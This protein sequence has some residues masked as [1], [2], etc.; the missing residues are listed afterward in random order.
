MLFNSIDFMIF[1]PIV[2]AVYFVIPKSLRGGGRTAWLLIAS[3]YFYM[4]WNPAYALLIAGST[5]VTF[6]SGILIERCSGAEDSQNNHYKRMVLILCLMIN[7]GILGV[8]KYGN[9]LIDSANEVLSIFHITTISRRF[10]LLLPV[11]I[12]F[13]T[14][15]ALGYIID[16]YRNDIKAEKNIVRYA[17]F[18][19][20]F[21]QLVAGPIERSKNLLSQIQNISKIKLWNAKRVTSGAILMVWGYF[22]KMVIADRVSLLVDTVFDN[23]RM[24]GSTELIIAAIGFSIQIYCDFGSYSLIAIGAA[25]IRG[26]ELMENFNT[27]Y[28]AHNIRDFWSRWHI[29]LSTWFRDYLYIPL[30]GNRKGKVRKAANLMIV[31]L[32]S[33]LWHGADWRFVAW[34]GIHGFYQVAADFLQPYRVK[35][36]EKLKIKT[37]C[38]S[39]SFLQVIVTFGLVAFAWIFF[40]SDSIA[41]ALRFIKRIFM[42]PT[43]W[44]LFNGGIFKLGLDR[45]E[46]NILV[47]SILLLIL[48][49]L[50]RYKKKVTIDVFLMEQNLW[51]EWAAVMGIIV[52]IF[53]FGE[54]GASFDA[55]QFIYFQF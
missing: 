4:S 8:F 35:I 2:V 37:N 44:L 18:V 53:I 15:Q 12:S 32:V 21:P 5:L 14:F 28:F 45:V 52:M 6:I 9:F 36:Q 29:S 43:P 24:Y 20:F 19:S 50:V 13:Y 33:G 51:F 10:D 55:Q 22:M 42:K 47:F 31:F 38:F 34:G 11:G 26:F 30:G 16:V 1:F 46:M 41:D 17:L 27:P 7:L 54:Y 40:R 25:K 39:W 3:Y 48:V 49:D 23:Y